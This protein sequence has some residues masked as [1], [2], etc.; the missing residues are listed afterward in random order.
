[1]DI[2]EIIIGTVSAILVV[3]IGLTILP[4]IATATGQSPLFGIILMMIL[5]IA[6]ITSAILAIFRSFG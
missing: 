1:M 2:A 5:L 6:V 4:L 3:F